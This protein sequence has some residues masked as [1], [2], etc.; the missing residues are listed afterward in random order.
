MESGE[1]CPSIIADGKKLS[2]DNG[3]EGSELG[4]YGTK[5]AAVMT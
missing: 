3:Q 4:S 2:T 5:Q 1:T